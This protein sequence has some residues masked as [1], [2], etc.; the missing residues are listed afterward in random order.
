MIFLTLCPI[1]PFYSPFF[2]ASFV[3]AIILL[4]KDEGKGGLALLLMTLFVPVVVGVVIFI[5]GVGTMLAAFFGFVKEAENTQKAYMPQQQA[6]I[7][8]LTSQQMPSPKP[9]LPPVCVQP[10]FL[11]PPPASVQPPVQQ[12]TAQPLPSRE[13]TYDDLLQVLNE[14]GEEY[15][16]ADTT[17]QKKDVRARAQAKMA[18][19]VENTCMTLAGIV[20]DVQDGADGKVTLSFLSF[21]ASIPVMQAHQ[22]LFGPSSGRLTASFTTE[23]ALKIK[24]GQKVKITGKPNVALRGNSLAAVLDEAANPSLITFRFSLDFEPLLTLRMRDYTVS[25]EEKKRLPLPNA[26]SALSASKKN[27]YIVVVGPQKANP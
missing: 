24:K 4:A 13:I 16:Q 23:E 3:L 18:S 17:L 20:R 21:D 5:L 14:F 9:A 19:F 12:S 25:F 15:K 8:Q 22:K 27:N 6:A 26:P 10:F 1:I 7:R 2:V 11:Q